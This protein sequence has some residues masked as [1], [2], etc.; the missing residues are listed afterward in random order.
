MYGDRAAR[1][2]LNVRALLVGA[3]HHRAEQAAE[4]DER[5]AV[6]VW[7]EPGAFERVPRVLRWAA[8]VDPLGALSVRGIAATPV[9]GSVVVAMV[10]LVA[11]VIVTATEE[12]ASVVR[13]RCH[14]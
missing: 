5:G 6:G 8:E 7:V 13:E 12:D 14:A 11:M 4:G 10:V 2:A 1:S 3:V 9:G